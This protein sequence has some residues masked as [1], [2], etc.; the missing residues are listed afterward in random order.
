MRVTVLGKSPAWPDAGGACSGYLIREAGLTLLMD[1]GAGVFARLREQGS[2][3]QVDAIVLSHLHPDHF[4]DLVPYAYAL[5]YG[6]ERGADGERVQAR[7][8][9]HAPPGGRE[10]FRRMGGAWGAE[11]LLDRAFDV[12]EYDPVAGLALDPLVLRFAPVPHYVPTWAIDVRSPSGA[13][14][15]FG[16]DHGPG[17]EIPAF[18]RDTDLLL[19]EA[20]LL[21]PE[22]DEPRGHVTAA[23]AGELARLARARRV[24]LTHF[25]DQLD[26]ARVEGDAAAAFGGPVALARAGDEYEL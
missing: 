14:L 17:P 18:A 11:D 1:C 20:T 6:G 23:E 26:P 12:R 4:I 2:Y 3:T 19:I 21:E 9:L 10:T 15:T 24:V 8:V 5:L 25:S 7:P 22:A 16:A 13:R